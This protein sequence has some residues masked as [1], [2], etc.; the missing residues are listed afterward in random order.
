MAD[1]VRYNMD[2]MATLF[3]QLEEAKLFNKASAVETIIFI[4]FHIVFSLDL[5][6]SDGFDV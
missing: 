4:S 6:L 5:S 2:R 1:R 3:R